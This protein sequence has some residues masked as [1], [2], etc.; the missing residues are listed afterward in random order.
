MNLGMNNV[1]LLGDDD[2]L[3]GW[4]LQLELMLRRIYIAIDPSPIQVIVCSHA[5]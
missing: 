2:L 4:C 5:P 3:A 1:R